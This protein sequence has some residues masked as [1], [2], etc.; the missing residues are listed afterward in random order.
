M[1]EQNTIH[2]LEIFL[3]KL[4]RYPRLSKRNCHLLIMKTHPTVFSHVKWVGAQTSRPLSGSIGLMHSRTYDHWHG[5][6]PEKRTRRC[7]KYAWFYSIL[8]ITTAIEMTR[9][10]DHVAFL[11]RFLFFVFLHLVISTYSKPYY[12]PF[13]ILFF[14][15]WYR[16]KMAGQVTVWS[17]LIILSIT[18]VI[19]S[20]CTSLM[21]SLWTGKHT[22]LDTDYLW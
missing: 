17:C 2:K 10:L 8:F 18:R 9:Q 11:S 7:G 14:D 21:E 6:W 3:T 16:L 13:Y 5:S 22:L 1:K 12:E 15:C 4:C 19:W 20:V